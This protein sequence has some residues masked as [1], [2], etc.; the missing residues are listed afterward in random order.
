MKMRTTRETASR[1]QKVLEKVE[2]LPVDDQT[3]LI[4][5]IHQRVIQHRRTEL[6]GEIAEARAAYE[7]GEIHRGSV[8]D[9]M[10][11]LGE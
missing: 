11:E 10:K 5:I 2:S 9:L 8:S 3:L 7:L 1:F 6:A 4:E